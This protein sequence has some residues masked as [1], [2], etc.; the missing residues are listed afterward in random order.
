LRAC[1]HERNQTAPRW[2]GPPPP[3]WP[4]SP[5][6]LPVSVWPTRTPLLEL[7]KS[8]PVTAHTPS[9]RASPPRVGFLK[10]TPSHPGARGP[11]PPW[12]TR[13]LCASSRRLLPRACRCAR[14]RTS[15]RSGRRS[16]SRPDSA[17]RCDLRPPETVQCRRRR[18][19]RRG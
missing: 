6:R 13:R 19:T 1:R 10:P 9:W 12:L 2:G 16:A 18:S 8:G 15:A 3:P 14:A 5:A 17:R 4:I 11:P 7:Q